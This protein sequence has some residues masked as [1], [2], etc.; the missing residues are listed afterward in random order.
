LLLLFQ[1]S[2]VVPK[3]QKQ[4]QEDSNKSIDNDSNLDVQSLIERILR[5]RAMLRDA[6][7]RSENPVDL[8]E[9]LDLGGEGES[10]KKWK[11][12]YY[13]LKEDFEKFKLSRRTPSPFMSP[14]S[15][16]SRFLDSSDDDVVDELIK[17]KS[18]VQELNEK[19]KYLSGQLAICETKQCE[20]DVKESKLNEIISDQKLKSK[21]ALEA[22]EG[23]MKLK[24]VQLELEVQKQRDRCLALIEE[25]DEEISNL[26]LKL[27]AIGGKMTSSSDNYM[28]DLTKAE[29]V[30]LD[31]LVLHYSDELA[32][33]KN[34]L[35]ELRARK[36]EL[37]SALHELQMSALAKEQNY[38]D[39]IEIMQDTMARL[40]RMATKE[41]A[42]LEYLKNVSLNYML[43][44]DPKSKEHMLKAIGAV[45]MFSEIEIKQVCDYNASWWPAPTVKKGG[46][47]R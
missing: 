27:E 23:E 12:S 33:N 46:G 9:L 22:K 3:I 47:K 7:R 39:K 43:S 5:L 6:N 44:T 42:N 37:E 8:D 34:E 38:Q 32:Y 15:K 1:T 17:L 25:K 18:H 2:T 29:E 21:K 11:K 40:K 35:R 10:L 26:K 4:G 20:F 30:K 19:I 13:Q 36:M 31:T 16:N 41:G 24:S 14:Q 45:L 28:Q